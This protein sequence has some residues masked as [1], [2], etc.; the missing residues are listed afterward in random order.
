MIFHVM[1]IIYDYEDLNVRR[2]HRP[3]LPQ[4]Q[5]SIGRA[6]TVTTIMIL[7]PNPF[8]SHYHVKLNSKNI[9]DF[10]MVYESNL[11]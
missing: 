7:I 6:V 5:W 11:Y 10:P 9:V 2:N 4:L 1:F 8:D 3:H